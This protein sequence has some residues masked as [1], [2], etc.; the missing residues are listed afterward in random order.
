MFDT[1]Q[2]SLEFLLALVTMMLSSDKEGGQMRGALP[3]AVPQDR[4]PLL[5]CQ[6]RDR[7]CRSLRH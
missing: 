6:T 3:C 1:N 7:D 4:L 2:V 5:H